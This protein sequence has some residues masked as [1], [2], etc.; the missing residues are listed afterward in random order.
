[1]HWEAKA[2]NRIVGQH[3]VTIEF[4]PAA[5]NELSKLG[6]AEA[7]RMTQTLKTRIARLGDPRRSGSALAGELG[8]LWR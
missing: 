2:Q 7:K 4:L 1:V 8:G 3:F 5:E 6:R